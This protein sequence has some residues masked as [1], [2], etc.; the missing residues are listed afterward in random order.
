MAI[1]AALLA[2]P[3]YANT[4]TPTF[5]VEV[6][7]LRSNFTV[8]FDPDLELFGPRAQGLKVNSINFPLDSGLIFAYQRNA[9][10][11]AIGTDLIL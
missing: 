5:N 1:L 9:D 6:G 4:I 3:A 10:A 11:L 2:L 8:T 7:N